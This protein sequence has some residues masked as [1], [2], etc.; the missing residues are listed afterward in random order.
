MFIRTPHSSG[1]L[2]VSV[3]FPPISSVTGLSWSLG[4][5]GP[6]TVLSW[7]LLPALGIFHCTLEY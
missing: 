2:V 1:F 5:R 3:D 6:E 4:Q 7:K